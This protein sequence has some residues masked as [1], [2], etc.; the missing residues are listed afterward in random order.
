MDKWEKAGAAKGFL[1]TAPV[2][3]TQIFSTGFGEKILRSVFPQVIFPHSTDH[4]DCCGI[5][6]VVEGLLYSF[7][8]KQKFGALPPAG[9]FLVAEQESTQRSQPKGALR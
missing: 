2:W 5:K 3:K 1:S 7:S 8:A 6:K 4:V 9:H